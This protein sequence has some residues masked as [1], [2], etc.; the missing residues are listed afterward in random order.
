MR[1]YGAGEQLS[2]DIQKRVRRCDASKRASRGT[3]GHCIALVVPDAQDAGQIQIELLLRLQQQPR[4]WLAA[5]A[6][7]VPVVWTEK[8]GVDATARRLSL[9]RASARECC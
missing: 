6:A 4:F 8:D 5:G 1:V 9:A 7:F 3:G 2:N